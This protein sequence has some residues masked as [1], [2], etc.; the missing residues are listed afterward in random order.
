MNKEYSLHIGIN[1][2]PGTGNDLSGCVNDALDTASAFEA[3]GFKTETLLDSDA[4]KENILGAMKRLVRT[5]GYRDTLVV[6]MSS[7]G[8]WIPDQGDRDEADLRDEVLCA[9]DFQDD[10]LI[11][12]DELYDLFTTR[13]FGARVIFLS[14]SCFSG[15][16]NRFASL[17]ERQGS[18]VVREQDKIARPRFMPPSEFLDD[19][20]L[21]RA[22]RI[23]DAPAKSIMRRSGAATITGCAEN[24]YSYDAW[25]GNRPNGAFTYYA[26]RS[27]TAAPI[28]LKQ[29]HANVRKYLP[30]P[31]SYPQAPQLQGTWTQK[32]WKV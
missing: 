21:R 22:Q 1:N 14:D 28:T 25:F 32:Q 23:V 11:I 16:I 30:N 26:L 29:L 6:S 12:D 31:N 27:L 19:R 18:S 2:Y 9:Y 10:G 7:H 13:K 4:T 24:E 20:D 15:T 5:I 17:P 3:R 8:S